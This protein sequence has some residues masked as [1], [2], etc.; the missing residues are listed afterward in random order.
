MIILVVATAHTKDSFF[1]SISESALTQYEKV[2]SSFP[3]VPDL[4]Q[5]QL[6]PGPGPE[7]QGGPKIMRAWEKT[8]EEGK[9]P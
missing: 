9:L 1:I 3:P 7:I 6:G 8:K 4:P 2:N 5:G